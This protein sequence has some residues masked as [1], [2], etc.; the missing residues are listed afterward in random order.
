MV[1]RELVRSLEIGIKDAEGMGGMQCGMPRI[2]IQ[3][4]LDRAKYLL[5]LMKEEPADGDLV[6][7]MELVAEDEKLMRAIG[8]L[9]V[10]YEKIEEREATLIELQGQ[11]VLNALLFLMPQLQRE[12]AD[13]KRA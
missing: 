8:A 12:G 5:L 1:A 3:L 7:R 2:N 9:A 4:P 10:F 11:V 13:V 6:D